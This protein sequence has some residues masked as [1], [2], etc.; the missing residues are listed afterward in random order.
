MRRREWNAEGIPLTVTERFKSK[1]LA[2]I[3][4]SKEHY[5]QS[6]PEYMSPREFQRPGQDRSTTL[7]VAVA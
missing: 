6:P 5:L 3:G 1:S 4:T 2:K 7:S